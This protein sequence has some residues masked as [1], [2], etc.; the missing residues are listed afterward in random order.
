MDC[1]N[2]EYVVTVG[3]TLTCYKMPTTCTAF[4]KLQADPNTGIFS[5]APIMNCGAGFVLVQTNPSAGN[6]LIICGSLVGASGMILTQI[7]CGY[8]ATYVKQ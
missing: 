6:A 2:G 3:G 7:M 4:E 8:G 5:C 1:G